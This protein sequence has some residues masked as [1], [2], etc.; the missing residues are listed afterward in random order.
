MKCG[1]AV[2][3]G[4]STVSAYLCSLENNSVLVKYVEKNTQ[5][6]YGEDVVS[7]ILFAH[8]NTVEKLQKSII[9]QIDTMFHRMVKMALKKNVIIQSTD[10]SKV[11]ITG[12]TVMLHFFIGLPVEGLEAAPFEPNSLFGVEMTGNGVFA[13]VNKNQQ[14]S[15]ISIYL[16]PCIDAFVG[17]DA[18]CAVLAILAKNIKFP[19]LMVDIGTNTEIVLMNSYNDFLSCST[20]AGPAFEGGRIS[21][22][23]KGS[24]LVA[25][26]S[27]MLEE[28]KM[29]IH[30]TILTDGCLLNQK[31]VRELQLAKSAISAAIDTLL[32]E[33]CLTPEEISSCHICG[34]FGNA[35]EVKHM[36]AIGLLPVGF[37]SRCYFEGNAA[38]L[39]ACMILFDDE[40]RAKAK[41]IVNS[42]RNIEL[43][44]N[45]FFSKRYIERMNFIAE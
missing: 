41:S 43:A 24:Q 20:A 34:T 27:R 35:L 44:N 2:D 45:L 23:M 13:L 18:V 37:S 7:R 19:A 14:N 38:G 22:D 9:T 11:V 15:N 28:N 4:T 12:N 40:N 36:E 42:T 16:C 33:E 31:D 1:F 39:G 30:G 10:V 25:I 17:S 21:V 32:N 5:S 3:I 6:I 8:N 26:L 29:D